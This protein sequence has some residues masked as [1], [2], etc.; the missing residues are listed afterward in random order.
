MSPEKALA[1]SREQ[2]RALLMRSLYRANVRQK[3]VAHRRTTFRFVAR[4]VRWSIAAFVAA[5]GL[6]WAA[7]AH[8][9]VPQWRIVTV[10]QMQSV[11]H[12]GATADE[13]ASTAEQSAIEAGSTPVV[14]VGQGQPYQ[15]DPW[16][17]EPQETPVELKAESELH[18]LMQ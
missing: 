15:E 5:A 16:S 8:D 13:A 12:L 3:S 7:M 1:M 14:T 10:D 18:S 6:L 9:L 11:E 17:P 2:T 4:V